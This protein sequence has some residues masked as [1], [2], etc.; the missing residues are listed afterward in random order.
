MIALPSTCPAATPRLIFRRLSGTLRSSPVTPPLAKR[1]VPWPLNVPMF[2]S[3]ASQS[4]TGVPP[5]ASTLWSFPVSEKKPIDRLSGAQKGDSAFHT[6]QR[7][8][9]E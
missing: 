7:L 4:V 1:I 5:A 2:A 9:L 8:G 3:A 6:R